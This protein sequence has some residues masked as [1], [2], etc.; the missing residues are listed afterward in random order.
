MTDTTSCDERCGL[1]R[2]L[3]SSASPSPSRS[4]ATIHCPARPGS[5]WMVRHG[6]ITGTSE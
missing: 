1:L 3:T 2:A 5:T 4:P 6:R